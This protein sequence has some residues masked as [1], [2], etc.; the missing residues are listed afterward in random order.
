MEPVNVQATPGA[1]RLLQYL[2]GIGGQKIIT[3]QH[4]QTVA[5]E[6]IGKIREI[7]GKEPALRGFELLAYSPNIRYETGDEHCRKEID[8]N[9]DTLEHALAF[10]R[11][12]GIVTL[13]WHWFSPLGGEDKSFY[14][15]KTDFDP[16]KVLMEGT[17][18]R[19]AFYHDLDVMAGCLKP[20]YEEDIPVLW[21]P[22]HE[23]EGDW[24]WWGRKGPAVAAELYRLQFE[25]F[26]NI[27]HLDNL[28][29][30]WNCP[31]KEGYPGDDVVDILSRDL[32]EEKGTKTDYRKEYEELISVTE[33]KKPVALAEIGILPDIEMLSESRVPWCYFMVWSK[34]FVMTE[35]FNSYNALRNIYNSGYAVTYPI[36][37]ERI[38]GFVKRDEGD[39]NVTGRESSR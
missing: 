31:L 25:Y 34:G 4:T 28:L 8:E 7:T 29:W 12:G 9:K 30:V 10:G 18:E 21:R 24:F 2:S 13:T 15:I 27:R 17:E 19:Q 33:A 1:R 32:Y 22:F 5:M 38:G 16:E 36:G 39:C 37:E 11:S 26:V 3:G 6:E 23:S 20:F 14:T 35:E